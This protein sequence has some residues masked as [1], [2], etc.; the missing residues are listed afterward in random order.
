MESSSAGQPS[1]QP[2]VKTPA[3]TV[4][5]AFQSELLSVNIRTVR[6]CCRGQTRFYLRHGLGV[7]TIF[8]TVTRE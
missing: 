5:L 2:S 1:Y 8:L 6:L 4:A 7:Q 3:R